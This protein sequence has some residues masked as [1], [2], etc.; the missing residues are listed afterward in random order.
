M[1]ELVVLLQESGQQ[2]EPEVRRRLQGLLG[3][4]LR[5]YLPQVWVFRT[6]KEVATLRVDPEGR[7][8]VTEGPVEPAD[9]TVEVPLRR[10]ATAL[11]NQDRTAIP[12]K[13]L[14]VTTHT[15]KGKTAFDYLRS[16][17]GL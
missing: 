11:R 12:A 15:A 6:E 13:E 17:L 3:G 10:L 7:V 2:W 14:K 4:I 5:A 8:T 16:R 1:G 9:V